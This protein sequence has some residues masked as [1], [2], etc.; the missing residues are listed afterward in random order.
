M[1]TC[2]EIEDRLS[3]FVDGELD[4]AAAAA[5]TAHLE[6]CARCAGIARDFERLRHSARALGP[7]DP[8]SHLGRE[9]ARRLTAET[10]SPVRRSA[11]SWW[12]AGVAAAAL[13]AVSTGAYLA[14]RAGSRATAPAPTVGPVVSAAL[15]EQ[16][17]SYDKAIAE[18]EGAARHGDATMDPTLAAT[19]QKNLV[20]LDRAISDSRSALTQDPGSESARD[21][22]RE[23]LQQKA[24]V[25]QQTVAVITEMRTADTADGAARK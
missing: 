4:G 20:T 25:L 24:T 19:L 5:I 18:L 12:R 10:P 16:L 21:S 8:P 2:E 23:A 14:F 11:S 3:D 9:L 22:L 17:G 15:D 13:V 6:T 1:M 7:I